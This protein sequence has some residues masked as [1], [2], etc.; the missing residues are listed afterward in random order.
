M[1]LRQQ[2]ASG[3]PSDLGYCPFYGDVYVVVETFLIGYVVVESFLIVALI[4][5][6]V[7]V[8]GSCFVM[9]C[10]VSFL[11]SPIVCNHLASNERDSCFNFCLLDS[12]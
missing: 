3:S 2:I 8:F 1:I 12:I 9:Q 5:W 4:V 11:V 7:F 10:L 6:V